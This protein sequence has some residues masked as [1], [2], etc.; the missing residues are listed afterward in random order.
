MIQHNDGSW[1]YKP[2]LCSTRLIDGANP[3]VVSWDLLQVDSLIL[4]N[5]GIARES[6]AIH[7]YYNSETICFAVSK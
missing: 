1:S 7:N 6:G 5:F 4:Y 2:G 3:S